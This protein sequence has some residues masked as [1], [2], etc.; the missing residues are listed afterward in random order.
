VKKPPVRRPGA[1]WQRTAAGKEAS[2]GYDL[3]GNILV[4]LGLGWV[5]QHYFPG[6]SPWGYGVGIVLGSISGFYQLFRTQQR[7]KSP[8]PGPEHDGDHV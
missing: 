5:A 3:A 8:P 4:G 2:A 1:L 7:P 6:L